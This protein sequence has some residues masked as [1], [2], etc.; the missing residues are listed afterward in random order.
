[1]TRRRVVDTSETAEDVYETFMDRG[2]ERHT[3]MPF[4]WPTQLQEVGIGLA[5]MYRSNKWKRKR[6]DWED[7]K[8]VAEGEQVVMV[9]PGFIR[10]QAGKRV[11]THGPMVK[12]Q[13]PMPSH[14][15]QLAPFLGIQLQLYGTDGKVHG[16][17]DIYQVDVAHAYWGGARFPDNDEAFLFVFTKREGVHMLVT[18]AKLDIE[19]DG[20]VG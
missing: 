10:D 6:T 1:M 13:S 5:Q 7:Y 20:I 16:D 17:E 11:K 18:G 12:L 19:K 14:F 2:H 4:N 8:H 9:E 15:A 3:E